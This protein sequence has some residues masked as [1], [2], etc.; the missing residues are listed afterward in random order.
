MNQAFSVSITARG[1]QTTYQWQKEGAGW[2]NLASG[3]TGRMLSLAAV[4][5]AHAGRYRF[6][7]TN[8]NGSDTSRAF[9]LGIGN[10]SRAKGDPSRE[11]RLGISSES[12]RFRF[13]LS[14]PR[15]G[16]VEFEIISPDG[17][18]YPV[19]DQVLEAGRHTLFHP[20]R[21]H[22]KAPFAYR[23]KVDGESRTGTFRQ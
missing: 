3:G 20:F 19:L 8:A 21:L 23:L 14:L 9:A 18:K 6:I 7:V 5:A 12:G 17:R 1:Y 11:L 16:K 13:D 15:A 4:N 10:V 22:S 2:Q